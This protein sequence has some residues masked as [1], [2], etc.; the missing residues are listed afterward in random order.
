M[1]EICIVNYAGD[2]A[3][4]GIGTYL[5][6]YLYCLQTMG[7]KIHLIELGTD[8]IQPDF[9]I[10]DDGCI[11]TIH[12]PYM[13][14]GSIEKY[15]KSVCRL[16]RLYIEDSERLV[17]HFHYTLSSGLSEGIK[18]YFPLSKSLLTIHYL[19]GCG[20]LQGNIALF[21]KIIKKRDDEK[22]KTKYQYIIETY[23]QEKAFYEK[24]DHLVCLSED[25]L[26]L[27]RNLY[28]I[29]SNVW[30]IPNGLRK[31]RRKLS[32][33]QKIHFRKSYYIRPE[34]TILLYVG[35]IT[36]SKG[37]SI[38]LSC[39]D[40]VLA[41]HPDC[42]LVMIG[43]GDINGAVNRCGK[44]GSRVLFTGRLTQKELYQWYQTAD[45]GIFPSLGEQCSYV[46]IEMMMHGLPIIASDGYGVKNMFRDGWNARIAPIEAGKNL[47]KFKKNLT[48]IILIHWNRIGLSY[49][50]EPKECTRRNIV[51]K[52]C[53]EG[54]W[55]C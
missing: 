8:R 21:E 26:H 7:C 16:L 29:E 32:E 6:E 46:G 11:R 5:K 14:N 42:R 49:V 35:R 44:A 40:E 41:N 39:F 2:A 36:P 22:I 43:G 15:N 23:R 37:I 54:I 27:V 45:I 51:S 47:S 55:N 13:K 20:I 1:K 24:M 25:T 4:Y 18:K 12:I 33:S 19:S 53:K 28:G 31:N 10:R 34:E 30:L 52:Q 50:K 3:V 48:N 17:F 9:Y 38:L